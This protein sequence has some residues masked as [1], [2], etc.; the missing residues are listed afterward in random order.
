MMS[1]ISSI[2]LLTNLR[3]TALAIS[4]IV[5]AAAI[6]AGSQAIAQDDAP[7]PAPGTTSASDTLSISQSISADTS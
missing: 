1:V 4:A 7:P 5:F 2:S 6:L 3:R